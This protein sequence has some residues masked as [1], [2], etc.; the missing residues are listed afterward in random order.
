M[1]EYE[2]RTASGKILTKV[3]PANG[4]EYP[5][6]GTEHLLVD[7]D[8]GHHEIGTRIMS[9][10]QKPTEV[11]KPYTSNRLPRFMKGQPCTPEGKVRVE[12]QAQE[13]DIMAQGGYE[14]E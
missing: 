6:V 10:P 7:P 13:R 5:E 4:P 3:F 8:T 2:F 11:W 14:R 9:T 1:P 12:T